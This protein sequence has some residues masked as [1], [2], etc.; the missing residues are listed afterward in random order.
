MSYV[1]RIAA[2]TLFWLIFLASGC[3]DTGLEA[4]PLELLDRNQIITSQMVDPVTSNQ[5][6]TPHIE[7]FGGVRM[8]LVPPGCLRFRRKA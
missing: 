5:E 8:A 6:W 2:I 1:G 4:Q 3:T 7:E